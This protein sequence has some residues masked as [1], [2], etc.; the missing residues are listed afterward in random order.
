MII[1]QKANR[2][3]IFG[4]FFE[5]EL[6]VSAR[7]SWKWLKGKPKRMVKKTEA[8]SD[9]GDLPLTF[10]DH[11]VNNWANRHASRQAS[12]P[13]PTK[14]ATEVEKIESSDPR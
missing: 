8:V 5:R 12:D 14:S 7:T 2:P 4:M 3:L 6:D 11:A 10:G 13:K 9:S 1:W